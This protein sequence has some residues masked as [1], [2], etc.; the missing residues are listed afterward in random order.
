ML[1]VRQAFAAQAAHCDKL[2]SPF[3]ALLCRALAEHL[4]DA[5]SAGATILAWKGDPDAHADALPLRVAG[6]LHA[7]VRSGVAPDLARFYPPAPLPEAGPLYAAI[8]RVLQSHGAAIAG[9]LTRPP[10]TNEVGR[11]ALLLAGLLHLSDRYRKPV[12]LYELGASAGLNL[13]ADRYRCRFGD[14]EWTPPGATLTLEP[15]WDGTPPLVATRLAIM[16]RRGCDLTPLE[17]SD[18]AERDRLIAYTWPDQ[19][20]RLARLEAAIATATARPPSVDRMDAAR[21]LELRLAEPAPPNALTV[22]WHSMFWSYLDPVQRAKLED[23]L[24]LAG[25][26]ATPSQPVAWL[27]MELDAELPPPRITALRLKIWPHGEEKRLAAAHPHGASVRW[28]P[29]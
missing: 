15:Q 27:R 3:T 29:D 25:E 18:P 11:S 1:R 28:L 4:C 7:L 16:K 6:A 13:L 20:Q 8:A 23:L 10:Q 9:F 12:V 22:I 14:V 2:G 21:W 19:P 5:T 26:A 17:L 24:T